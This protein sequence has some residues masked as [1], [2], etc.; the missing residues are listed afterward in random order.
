[1][2]RPILRPDCHLPIITP[3][4]EAFA[5]R[6]R[7]PLGPWCA[8][9]LRWKWA[10]D[11]WSTSLSANPHELAPYRKPWANVLHEWRQPDSC[12]WGRTWSQ[13]ASG[14]AKCRTHRSSLAPRSAYEMSISVSQH[15]PYF[16]VL[17]LFVHNGNRYIFSSPYLSH[18][19]E[20]GDSR[21]KL[22]KS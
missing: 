8:Q 11:L 4:I 6:G 2:N 19:Y 15:H 21:D 9:C 3:S 1:M 18:L 13:W 12:H 16:P 7:V 20:T 5:H 17:L 14:S 22:I 10:A